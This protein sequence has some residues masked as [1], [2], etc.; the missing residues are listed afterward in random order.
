MLAP[1]ARPDDGYFDLVLIHDNQRASYARLARAVLTRS[2]G[3]LPQV[4][5]HRGRKLEIAWR[6]F[7]LH[8]DGTATAGLD[9]VDVLDHHFHDEEPKLL[10]VAKPII[11]VEL[12]PEKVHFCVPKKAAVIS[13]A[14]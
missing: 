9:G 6:G 1:D 7:P 14:A 8:L 10:D 3:N 11:R 13:G 4:S 2:L 12:A 5:I